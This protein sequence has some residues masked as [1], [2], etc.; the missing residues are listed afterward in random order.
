MSEYSKGTH[1]EKETLQTV[2]LEHIQ[3][4][5]RARRWGIFFKL[6]LIVVIVVGFSGLFK[7][8]ATAKPAVGSR[9]HTALIDIIGTIEANSDSSADNIRVAL[10]SAFD[11][12]QAK[13]IVLRINSPGGS[14]VQARQVFDEIRTLRA[15]NPTVKVYAAIEDMGTSA[16]YLIA[17]AADEIYS[18]QTSLVGSIGAKIDSFGFVDAMQK[19]GVQRRIYSSGKYKTILDAYSPTTVE[20]TKLITEQ[21]ESTHQAFIENVRVGRGARLNENHEDIFSGLFWSGSNALPLGLIDGFADAHYIARELIQAEK[22]ID[23][24]PNSNFLDRLVR[25][26][27]A[28]LALSVQIP[29]LQ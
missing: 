2:L 6:F 5:R 18:D 20:E 21:V 23:Y 27:G 12:K 7:K 26:V 25:R 4:Q 24:T 14:P 3:E 10:R 22:I 17:C 9:A 16:A 11:N 8:D 28:S 15:K 13:G 19:L 29:G 1:W